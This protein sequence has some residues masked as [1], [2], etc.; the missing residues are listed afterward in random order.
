MKNKKFNTNKQ[1]NKL[2]LKKIKIKI[3][4]ADTHTQCKVKVGGKWVAIG[5]SHLESFVPGR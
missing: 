4:Q 5:T 2:N 1:G 3:T